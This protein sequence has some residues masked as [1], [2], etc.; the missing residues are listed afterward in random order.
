MVILPYQ[1]WKADQKPALCHAIE[2][3]NYKLDY[4]PDEDELMHL[5]NSF[6][7]KSIK[8]END[9]IDG[10]ENIK[11]IQKLNYKKKMKN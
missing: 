1:K 2:C 4:N 11:K 7:R 9:N 10:K 6:F 3:I 8:N 5:K